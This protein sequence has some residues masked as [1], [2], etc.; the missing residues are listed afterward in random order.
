[1]YVITTALLIFAIYLPSTPTMYYVLSRSP[2]LQS[3]VVLYNNNEGNT[4]KHSC[5]SSHG[6]FILA[7]VYSL[8][9][10]SCQE[11]LPVSRLRL[12]LV[13]FTTCDCSCWLMPA[14]TWPVISLLWQMSIISASFSSAFDSNFSRTVFDLIS[15]YVVSFISVVFA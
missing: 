3:N 10:S 7:T 12:L 1:M 11:S 5:T 9:Y 14:I 13:P 2:L 4:S 8:Q 6:Y 15:Q